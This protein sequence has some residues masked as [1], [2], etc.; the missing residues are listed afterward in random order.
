M[1]PKTRVFPNAVAAPAL[2]LKSVA[3]RQATMG[4]LQQ[5]RPLADVA[6]TPLFADAVPSLAGLQEEDTKAKQLRQAIQQR[7]MTGTGLMGIA[8]EPMA[9]AFKRRNQVLAPEPI[10]LDAN[11]EKAL[12]TLTGAE[13]A[14]VNKNQEQTEADLDSTSKTVLTVVMLGAVLSV[15][16]VAM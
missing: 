2:D 16:L 8:A 6:Q 11:V 14:A 1:P 5:G 3:K 15:L 7:G 4:A 9:A 12:E 13:Q 10:K